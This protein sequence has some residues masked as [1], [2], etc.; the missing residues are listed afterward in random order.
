MPAHSSD[1][2]RSPRWPSSPRRRLPL[3]AGH[4]L[5]R[6]ATPPGS[7]R[8][9]TLHVAAS[10]S[11]L[12]GATALGG[13]RAWAQQPT[14][15]PMTPGDTIP[16]LPATGPAAA[17]DSMP[18]LRAPACA[19][20]SARVSWAADSVRA[21][22]MRA[23]ARADSM[24]VMVGADSVRAL[25]R[26]DS[27]CART[28]TAVSAACLSSVLRGDAVAKR[29]LLLVAGRKLLQ[30][31]Q[32]SNRSRVPRT[33]GEYFRAAFGPS[34]LLRAGAVAGLE[35]LLGRPRWLPRSRA[36]Y[37]GRFGLTLGANALATGIRYETG[38]WLG[39]RPAGFEP[40]GCQGTGAR[41]AHALASPFRAETPTGERFSPFTPLT[42]LSSGML[43]ATASGG[44]RPRQGLEA[45][46][47]GLLSMSAVAVLREFRPWEKWLGR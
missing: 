13:S 10:V 46:L 15:P 19:R 9:Y 41:L 3:C 17:G 45:G 21:D 2:S 40:C 8:A 16:A 30:H 12:V 31:A 44:F 6:S 24:R 25:A 11:L 34:A 5:P 4:I 18:V 36:G 37:G 33:S 1:L 22:S 42:E 43:Y 32:G 29:G 47:T 39:V 14:A 23:L 28:G 38:R 26:A 7:S 35:Q 27:T 20:D